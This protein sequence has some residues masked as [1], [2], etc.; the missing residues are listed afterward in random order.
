M[1]KSRMFPNISEIQSKVLLHLASLRTA[2]QDR[3]QMLDCSFESSSKVCVHN[4]SLIN[5]VTER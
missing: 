2:L 5:S 3:A 1:K 4:A